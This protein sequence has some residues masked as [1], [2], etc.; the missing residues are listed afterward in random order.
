MTNSSEQIQPAAETTPDSGVVF[1][2]ITAIIAAL[3]K[4][5]AQRHL[6]TRKQGGHEL[7]YIEWHTAVKYL[8]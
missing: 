7:T 5:L 6:K 2:S 4:P 1:R 8:D 3:S